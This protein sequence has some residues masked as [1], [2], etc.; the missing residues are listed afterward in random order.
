[1][2][3]P[4]PGWWSG[5][6]F[7][8]YVAAIRR[9]GRLGQSERPGRPDRPAVAVVAEQRRSLI[10]ATVFLF[11]TIFC[12]TL[13]IKAAPRCLRNGRAKAEGAAALLLLALPTG[14]MLLDVLRALL[15]FRPE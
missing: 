13:R 14:L 5:K 15:S 10:R 6:L 1:M 12:G 9:L 7:L 3:A 8:S 11:M 2:L 4:R